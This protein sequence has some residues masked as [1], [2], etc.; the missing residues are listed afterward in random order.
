M[1]L[2]ILLF[3]GLICCVGIAICGIIAIENFKKINIITEQKA[4]LL[5][6]TLNQE[7]NR[8][9]AAKLVEQDRINGLLNSI[10]EMKREIAELKGDGIRKDTQI[11]DLQNKIEVLI[12]P[13]AHDKY[14]GQQTVQDY[15]K[16][17]GIDSVQVQITVK[18]GMS[19]YSGV[20]STIGEAIEY[21]E[22]IK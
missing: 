11:A 7:N 14:I 17:V 3:C 16:E 4:E 8:E 22:D 1:K 12:N 13:S 19:G 6:R 5:Q 2:W 21:L 10:P 15:V 18:G 20:F 9:L